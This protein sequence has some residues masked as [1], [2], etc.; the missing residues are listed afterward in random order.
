M[1]VNEE[2]LDA[3]VRHQTYLT[4]YSGSV[5]NEIL[6]ILNK[7]ETALK[8]AI[9]EMLAEEIGLTPKN[10]RNL[11]KLE[12]KIKMI[13]GEAW[14]IVETTLLDDLTELATSEQSI[15]AGITTTVSPVVLNL[16][17]LPIEQ[18]TTII[19]THPFEGRTAREW[20]ASLKRADLRRIS[21]EIKIGMV[22]GQTTPE[23]ARRIVGT[24][25]LKGK[26]GV[27]NISRN[28]ATTIVRTAIN[29]L[30]NEVRNQFNKANSDIVKK[31]IYVSVLDGRTTAICKSLDGKI[32]DIGKGAKPPMHWNCRSLRV[33]YLDGGVLGERPSKPV[34]ER[35]LV[36]EYAEKNKLGKIT[37]RNDLPYGS[38]TSYDK[39]ARLRT[40]ELTGQVPAKTTYQEWLKRQSKDFQDDT[41]GVAKAKL[42]RKGGLTLD[43]FVNR[44][45]DE[46]TLSE[47]ANK[48]KQAFK[49]AG[50]DI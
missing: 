35:L 38:K 36:K 10:L 14:D 23:I 44:N 27:T 48:H 37:K 18:L 30:S 45:G 11:R 15:L 24:V 3:L 26:D 13:R 31:E 6:P 8:N 9:L 32:F 22:Q 16:K 29:S 2:Y 47:L 33:A 42:F 50:L 20:A 46:L 34:T 19:N 12:E 43:K 41:L 40:R 49:S 1:T 39:F 7:T 28:N 5:R 25:A 21:D 17:L 4:R